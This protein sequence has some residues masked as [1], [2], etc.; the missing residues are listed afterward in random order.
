MN[1]VLAKLKLGLNFVDFFVFK[2][3]ILESF[4]IEAYF[5]VVQTQISDAPEESSIQNHLDVEA[6]FHSLEVLSGVFNSHGPTLL[7]LDVM[8]VYNA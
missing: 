1:I 2:G 3:N 6:V 7:V 5:W 8:L 4:R